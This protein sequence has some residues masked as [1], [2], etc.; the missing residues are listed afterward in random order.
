MDNRFR[1]RELAHRLW[2]GTTVI[3]SLCSHS[4][5]L[6]MSGQTPKAQ[7]NDQEILALVDYL[8]TNKS[9]GEGAGSFKDSTFSGA[10]TAVSPFLS[11]GPP[12]TVKHCKT[13]WASVCI[14]TM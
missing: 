7:W 6:L 10:V 13:K 2:A 14:I 12:K 5:I 9:Q 11:G 1:R 4:A 3:A 8:E